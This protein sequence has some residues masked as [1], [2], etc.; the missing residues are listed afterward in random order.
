MTQLQNYSIPTLDEEVDIAI[1]MLKGTLSPLTICTTE[2]VINQLEREMNVLTGNPLE[3]RQEVLKK[4]KGL[5]K[6]L[7][8]IQIEHTPPLVL[9]NDEILPLVEKEQKRKE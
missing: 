8:Q 5:P 4:L 2:L 6:D 3:I 1:G 7:L 9:K